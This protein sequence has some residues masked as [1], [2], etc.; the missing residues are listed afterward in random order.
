MNRPEFLLHVVGGEEI[1]YSSEFVKQVILKS[2]QRC[3]AHNS[4]LREDL[5]DNTLT[6]ALSSEELRGGVF[7][8]VVG[9]NVNESVDVV[10]SNR[11]GNALRTVNMN[12]FIGKVPVYVS[13][14][15]TDNPEEKPYLVG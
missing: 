5:A 6:P 4:S 10:L 13:S 11:L 1:G 15:R 7:G 3:R 14:C 2:K 9:R 12:V 8:S